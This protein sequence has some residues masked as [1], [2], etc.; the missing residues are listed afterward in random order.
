[1]G[2]SIGGN[3]L[4]DCI[5]LKSKDSLDELM[6][7]FKLKHYTNLSDIEYTNGRIIIKHPAL[8]PVALI[9]SEYIVYKYIYNTVN[10]IL[11]TDYNDFLIWITENHDSLDL[12][13]IIN[14]LQDRFTFFSQKYKKISLDG[15][16]IFS[17]N[18]FKN[19]A[20]DVIENIM[21]DI[22]ED[23]DIKDFI[24][25]LKVYVYT[26]PSLCDN[27]HIVINPDGS[28]RYFDINKKD[29]TKECL[30]NFYNEFHDEYAMQND[31]LLSTLIIKLPRR[32]IL[33]KKIN[34]LNDN[35]FNTIH[36]IFGDRFQVCC[37][38]NCAFCKM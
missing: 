33:H 30:K 5:V 22:K 19:I 27:L 31:I 35:L 23:E 32:I 24:E 3:R 9:V 7:F 8:S 17:F 34:M 10:E 1:M 6:C 36:R 13:N 16:I 11:N 4:E 18:E 38:N 14:V 21:F 26:E 15:F 12:Q 29:I 37:D 28:Y 25:Q 20:D 2:E